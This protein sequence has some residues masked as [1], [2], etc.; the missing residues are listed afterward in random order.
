M[1]EIDDLGWKFVQDTNKKK[2]KKISEDDEE[3]SEFDDEKSTTEEEINFGSDTDD[4]RDCW[5][6]MF[7]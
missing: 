2:R 6:I 1:S 5:N 7:Y 4:S 3:E